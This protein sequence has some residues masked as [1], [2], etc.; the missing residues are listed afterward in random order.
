MLLLALMAT[1]LVARTWLGRAAGILRLVL[2]ALI[3]ERR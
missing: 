2:I 1:G 3:A